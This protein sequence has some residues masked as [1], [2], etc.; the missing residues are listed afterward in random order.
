MTTEFVIRNKLQALLR[1]RKA[2]IATL[3]MQP[4]FIPLDINILS[5]TLG[6]FLKNNIS[7]QEIRDSIIEYVQGRVKLALHVRDGKLYHGNVHVVS[8]NIRMHTPAIVYS[9]H[10]ILGIM[11]AAKDSYESARRGLFAEFLNNTLRSKLKSN[12]SKTTFRRSKGFNV[13]HTDIKEEGFDLGK[14]VSGS[15]IDNV[16]TELASLD[17]VDTF[18][19]AKVADVLGKALHY[20]EEFNVH[21]EYST[22]IKT[23]LTKSFKEALLSVNA[24]IVIIQEARDNKLFGLVESALYKEIS[25]LL[26]DIHFSRNFREE[27]SQRFQD[28]LDGL[29]TSNSLVKKMLQSVKNTPKVSKM[30]KGSIKLPT[31]RTIQGQFYSLTSLQTL[32]NTHLQNVVSAN[33]GDEGYPG[34]QRR[35][36]N[37]RTGRFASS[38]KVDRVTQSR[39]GMISAFYTYMRNPYQTFEPGYKMGSPKTRDPKLLIAKSI[40]EIAAT[41][42]GNRLRA[43]LT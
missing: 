18:Q 27:I 38:V 16:I 12:Y 7:I 17:L 5:T 30:E 13:G 36:L 9:G 19:A 37:Y 10:T 3:S 1:G 41:K 11:Y 24:N 33:M 23:S 22:E 15:Q 31:F 14:T 40:R 32:I 2:E 29:K 35:I 39:D 20:R 43:V 34:G 8:D 25:H 26:L 6:P 4:H 21:N 42:V 28:A